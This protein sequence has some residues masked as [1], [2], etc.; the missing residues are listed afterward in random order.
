MFS[1]SG[2]ESKR[3]QSEELEKNKLKEVQRLE[4]AEPQ[5]PSSHSEDAPL[6]ESPIAPS[7][8]PPMTPSGSEP[9]HQTPNES[10]GDGIP[11][12]AELCASQDDGQMDVDL[13]SSHP[14]SC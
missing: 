13:K 8:L 5:Q 9:R 6:P 12:R 3:E 1:S 4:K 11:Q 14:A 7:Y 2:L 10:A